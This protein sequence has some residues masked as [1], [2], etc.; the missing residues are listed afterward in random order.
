MFL[1]A[2][3]IDSSIK[4]PPGYR[5]SSSG[6]PKAIHQVKPSQSNLNYHSLMGL[7]ILLGLHLFLNRSQALKVQPRILIL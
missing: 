6:G 5:R 4:N 3:G 2:V 7:R 1:N